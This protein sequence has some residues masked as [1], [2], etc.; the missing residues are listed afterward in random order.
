MVPQYAHAS[1]RLQSPSARSS[2]PHPD[3]I[4]IAGISGTL[5]LNVV[6]L[7][8]LLVPVSQGT[9]VPAD[10]PPVPIR[11]IEDAPPPP[12]PPPVEVEVVQPRPAPPV[13]R[14]PVVEPRPA[15]AAIEPVVVAQGEL[16]APPV[17]ES[18]PGT[19]AGAGIES[20]P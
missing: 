17:I 15:P 4:R 19:P 13:Q 16:P 18:Q 2:G 14:R 1:S 7:L 5:V 12:A 11:W 8:L 10:G 9:L 3:P 6:A 20:G